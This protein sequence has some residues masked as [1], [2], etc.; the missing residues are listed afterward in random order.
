MDAVFSQLDLYH[1]KAQSGELTQE[2][3]QKEA[4][5]FVKGLRYGNGDYFW[6]NDT[7]PKMIM[8]PTVPKLD[9]VDLSTN[10]DKKGKHLFIEMV[11]AVKDR[12]THSGFVTYYWTRS[13]ATDPVPK[14]SY[15]RQ[16]PSWNWIVGTGIYIDDLDAA[17][18][19][20]MIDLSYV[21]VLVLLAL[22]FWGLLTIRSVDRA[23]KEIVAYVTASAEKM[24]FT[25]RLPRPF[26]PLVKW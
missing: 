20:T 13:D 17:F 24:S 26:M 10:Q 19:Q 1:K 16:Y 22:L 25:N 23:I 7:F 5:A 6:I 14:L 9:G 8:H 2:G 12:P 11:K 4:I 3:A 21:F 15:V 18:H